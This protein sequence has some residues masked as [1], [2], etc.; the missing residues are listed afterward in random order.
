[1]SSGGQGCYRC[2]NGGNCTAPDVCTCPPEWTGFDCKTPVCTQHA[3]VQTIKDLNTEDPA[4]IQQFELD[5]CGSELT[6]EWNGMTVGRGNC[7]SPDTCT[8]LCKS[9]S[10]LDADGNLVEE[11]WTD[12]LNRGLQPGFIYGDS[13]CLN[14]YQGYLNPDGSFRTCHLTIYVPTWFERN[15]ILIIVLVAVFIVV[16]IAVGIFVQRKLRQ[17]YVAMMAQ[18]RAS[19]RTSEESAGPSATAFG[20]P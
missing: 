7:S 3:D 20:A 5:P 8:C 9:R 6:E 11:P 14:G 13:D 15:T 16:A 18:R 10:W 12:P 17:R 1:M 2:A 19:R 4:K